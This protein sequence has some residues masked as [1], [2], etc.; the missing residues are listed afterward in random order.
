[1]ALGLIETYN[2]TRYVEEL[3]D[4]IEGQPPSFTVHLHQEYWILNNGSK[5]LYHNPM[6]VRSLATDQCI[7]ILTFL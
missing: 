6:A 1:M 7:V 5:F 3:L 4:S 2:R